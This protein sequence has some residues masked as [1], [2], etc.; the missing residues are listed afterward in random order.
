[1]RKHQGI[2]GGVLSGLRMP[3]A[4]TGALDRAELR[5]DPALACA[6]HENG[7]LA[8]ETGLFGQL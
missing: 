2:I 5:A 1:M 7:D 3:T 6:A 8:D 4:A